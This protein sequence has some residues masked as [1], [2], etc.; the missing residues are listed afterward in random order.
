MT[1]AVQDVHELCAAIRYLAGLIASIPDVEKR[2]LYMS[3]I[4]DRAQVPVEVIEIVVAEEI[5]RADSRPT[6]GTR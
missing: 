6:R 4:A 1:A 5:T 2:W 3:M